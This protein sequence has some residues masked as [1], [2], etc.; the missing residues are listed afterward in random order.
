[1]FSTT[2]AIIVGG[3]V[4]AISVSTALTVAAGPSHPTTPAAAL[5]NSSSGGTQLTAS[6][7]GSSRSASTA[8]IIANGSRHT[9]AFN[10]TQPTGSPS[11]TQLQPSS[12]SANASSTNAS[13]TNA[14]STSAPAASPKS[15]GQ[16]NTFGKFISSV[17]K[18]AKGTMGLHGALISFFAT[19]LNHGH[20]NPHAHTSTTTSTNSG[21]TTSGN[22][23]TTKGKH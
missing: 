23:G 4:L 10:A 1:M 20:N 17:A 13:S 15:N 22:S 14:S 18:A 16:G 12:S 9:V 6:L 3:G 19:A 11:Q 5:G 7:S 21:T 2:R 8:S